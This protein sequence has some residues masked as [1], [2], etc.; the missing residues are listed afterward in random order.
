MNLGSWGSKWHMGF[1]ST[2]LSFRGVWMQSWGDFSLIALYYSKIS[3]QFLFCFS[4][5]VVNSFCKQKF[6]LKIFFLHM[7]PLC[8]GICFEF[9]FLSNSYLVSVVGKCVFKATFLWVGIEEEDRLT[10]SAIS[11]V[12]EP[13]LQSQHNHKTLLGSKANKQREYSL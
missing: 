12:Y 8:L 5:T 3:V 2:P 6:V 1:E 7:F 10:E 11:L 4:K 13:M 9:L